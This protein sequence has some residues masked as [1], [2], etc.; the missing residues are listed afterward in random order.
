MMRSW[1]GGQTQYTHLYLSAEGQIDRS[2][3]TGSETKK[4]PLCLNLAPG[5]CALRR[6]NTAGMKPKEVNAAL[7]LLAEE[8]LPELASEYYLDSWKIDAETHGLAAL[9]RVLLDQARHDILAGGSGQLAAVRVPEL[10][11]PA[12]SSA[13]FWRTAAGVLGCLWQ[14]QRLYHWQVFSAQLATRSLLEQMAVAAPSPPQAIYLNWM[15]TELSTAWSEAELQ[16]HWPQAQVYDVW[17]PAD[18]R[19][20]FGQGP[21]FDSFLYTQQRQAATTSEKWRLGLAL[22]GTA[23]AGFFMFFAEVRYLERQVEQLAH[24][25]SLF[26]VQANRSEKVAARSGQALRQ[27]RELRAMSV[28]RIGVLAVLKALNDALPPRVKLDSISLDR[29]GLAALDGVAETELDITTFLERLGR[30][31]VLRE[32]N[33]A[34]TQKEQ[35]GGDAQSGLIRFRLEARLVQPLLSLPGEP[36]REA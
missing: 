19:G 3:L 14:D 31:A 33:L 2:A 4:T 25:A 15:S 20:Y 12:Q 30:S 7:A 11:P 29:T 9:P 26:K 1:F 18:Q 21:T 28:E 5:L 17:D 6:L 10:C 34:F 24:T 22:A 23:A 32:P 16:S 27:I 13:V 8:S 36:E 35:S